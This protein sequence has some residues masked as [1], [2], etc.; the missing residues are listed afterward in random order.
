MRR[1][2]LLWV[3][4]AFIGLTPTEPAGAAEEKEG[5]F[6]IHRIAVDPQNPQMV[7]AATSNYGILKSGDGGTTWA[8]INQG[9]GSYTHHA[10]VV[11]PSDPNILYAGAWGGGVSKS[12]DRGIHWTEMNRGL[13]NTAIE[14]L[15]L[16]PGHPEMVYVATTSG[17]FKSPDGGASWI[18]YGEGLPIARIEIFE[19]LIALPSGPV[20]LLLG[21]S[22]GLFERERNASKWAAV[23]LPVKEAHITAFAWDP[24]TGAVYAGTVKNGLL[25][26]RDGGKTWIALG[27]G[28]KN[29]WISDIA[30]DLHGSGILYASTRGHGI[31]KSLDGG[32]T[33][34]E[35]NGGLPV[36][37]IRSVAMAPGNSKILY[38]GTTYQGL[39]KTIDGGER[40]NP[41][42]GYPLMSVNE[43]VASLSGSSARTGISSEPSV[44]AEFFKCNR[45]HGWADPFL[46]KKKT[47]WRVP[48]NR[49]DWGM[50]VGRM[51][52]RARLTPDDSR[53][54][55]D[56]LTRY[57]LKK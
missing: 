17:V 54:I 40:W 15:V 43:I 10:L 36:K 7:Y 13:G 50:T 52:Q 21:T 39:V 28:F 24:R 42:K 8:L 47:Y 45:C 23:A 56:F 4:V 38:A 26:S 46:N 11:D 16:S 51:S 41:L 33:W 2:C 30:L 55:I 19:R 48:P 12:L 32:A 53:K 25:Q 31:I 27:G 3:L 35:A 57:T 29:V 34:K 20:E 44:P 37:D 9:I 49:R 6:V 18:F 14:D 5:P 22:R 1:A